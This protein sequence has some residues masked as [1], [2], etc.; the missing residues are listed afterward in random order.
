MEDLYIS[1]STASTNN[2]VDESPKKKWNGSLTI[3]QEAVEDKDGD[4]GG[5]KPP[6]SP[7]DDKRRHRRK[8]WQMGRLNDKKRRKSVSVLSPIP[9]AE[10]CSGL[11]SDGYYKSKRPSWWNI[12]AAEHWPR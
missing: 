12:F 4:E 2:N 3:L 1:A 8:S 9:D 6:M 10:Q 5:G 7:P 11:P